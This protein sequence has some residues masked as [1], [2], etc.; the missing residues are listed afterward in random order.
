[1]TYATQWTGLTPRSP[2]LKAR[3]DVKSADVMNYS[4]L[5]DNAKTM[6]SMPTDAEM[7]L[8]EQIRNNQ[9][10]QKFRRQHVI[11]PVC[12]LVGRNVA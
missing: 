5:E 3:G 9:L 10:G 11:G 2:L 1:M 4:L 8:W 7:V 6:R 12:H